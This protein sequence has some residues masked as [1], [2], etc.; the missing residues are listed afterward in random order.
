[1]INNP[2]MA[3]LNSYAQKKLTNADDRRN[4]GQGTLAFLDF[5]AS[6]SDFKKP[7]ERMACSKKVAALWC[8]ITYLSLGV[9]TRFVFQLF[10]ELE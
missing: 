10:S 2:N 9:D 5:C 3:Y 7:L 6:K 1:M 4:V 8:W